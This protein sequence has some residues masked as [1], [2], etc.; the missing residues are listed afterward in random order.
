[1]FLCYFVY[2]VII[3]AAMRPAIVVRAVLMAAGIACLMILIARLAA[4]FEPFAVLRDWLPLLYILFAYREMDWFTPA[5]RD[6]RL[7]KGWIV[8]DRVL[9]DDWGLRGAIESLGALVPGY[10]EL[11]YLLIYGVGA[12]S[13]GMFYFLGHRDRIDRFL[14]P[15]VAGTV[16]S[17]A[18]FPFFPSDPPREVFA[19]ADLP[20]VIT[21]IRTLN[22]HLVGNYGIHS[23]VFPSAHVSMA[24]ASAWGLMYFLPERPWVGRGMLIYA[25]SVAIATIYGRYHYAVDAAAGAAVGLVALAMCLISRRSVRR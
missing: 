18:M 22:L 24:F 9:L 17:Y 19:G 16:L 3:A 12:F 11:C 7:E 25:F 5:V 10:L 20:G 13:V 6:Y 14:A 23:S 8:W 2:V 4:R 1:M 15:Y 21:P